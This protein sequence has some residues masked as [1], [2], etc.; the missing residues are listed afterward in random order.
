MKGTWSRV[1]LEGKPADVYDLG[2]GEK[3][4]F[5]VLFLHPYGLETLVDR[6]ALRVS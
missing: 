1:E 4:R 2:C 5:G 3:P 6:P